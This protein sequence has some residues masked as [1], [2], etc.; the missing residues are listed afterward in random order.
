M[1]NKQ[2]I[3]IWTWY[4]VEDRLLFSDSFCQSTGIAKDWYCNFKTFL[5]IIHGNDLLQFVEDIDAI[6]E[7]AEPRWIQYWIVCP[8][9]T[10]KIID[11]FVISLSTEFSDVV[12]ITGV[13]FEG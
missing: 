9:N 5:E 2:P 4:S 3:G 12:D 10:V 11:C 6:L 1:D 8:G 13:C 7:G